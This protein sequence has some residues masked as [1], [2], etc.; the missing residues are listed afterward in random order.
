MKTM[1]TVQ[2]VTNFLLNLRDNDME[3]GKYYS[4]SNLKMQKLLYFC[5]GIFS[6]AN[7][8]NALI[9]DE[10]FEAWRY[11]PVI[12]SAYFRFN[13]YGQ[14]DIPK[15]ETGNFTGLQ[16]NEINVI[17]NVWNNLK[18]RSAFELVEASHVPDG[19]W[20]DVYYGNNGNVIAHEQILNYF[21]GQ[22]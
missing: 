2:Q 3:S 7:Q 16:S 4:L 21:G 12:P 13:M 22:R 5:H 17:Q 15:T 9:V 19:P 8:G 20:H 11:G 6:A 10:N 1:A 18:H 14:N